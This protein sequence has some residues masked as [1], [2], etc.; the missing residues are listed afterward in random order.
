MREVRKEIPKPREEAF[1][2]I[3]CGRASHLDEFC[4]HHKRIEKRHFDYA[5]NSYRNEFSDFLPRS[6]SHASP[7]TSSRALSHFSHRP[8]HRSYDFGL[9][10]NSFVSRCF[11]YVPRPYRG[12]RFPRRFGFPTGWSHTHIE[13]GHLDCPYFP[14]RD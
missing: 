7:R 5:R 3:F 2:C 14:H 9:R 6:Y 4:F 1:V 12:D 11:G 13:P 10:E 8:N